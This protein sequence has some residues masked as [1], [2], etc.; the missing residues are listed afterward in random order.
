MR[1]KEN[2]DMA[3]ETVPTVLPIQTKHLA[4]KFNMKATALRRILRSMP[5]YADGV[6]TNY[7]W[8]ENDPKI[9]AIEQAISKLTAEKSAR[10]EAAK[11]ALAARVAAATAQAK[12]DAKA[13]A[14]AK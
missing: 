10:A 7:R 14:P 4:A 9:K 12:V 11:A 2:I 6:H 13:A 5:E 3:K 8:A 1:G